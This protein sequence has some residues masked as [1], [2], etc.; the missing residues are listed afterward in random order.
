MHYYQHS[1]ADFNNAT[2]HL[3]R[4]ERSIYRDLIDMYYDTEKPLEADLNKLARR[5][6]VV[7]D[8]EK[9]A[10]K[11]VLDDFFTLKSDGW[12]QPRC[13]QELEE[14][15]A[16]GEEIK[17]REDNE[18]ERQR[19]HRDERKRLFSE[20]REKNVVPKWDIATEPLRALHSQHCNAPATAETLPETELKR[21]C[22]APA[23]AITNNHKP[24]TNNHKPITKDTPVSEIE[25]TDEEIPA[26][27]VVLRDLGVSIA[28][29]RKNLDKITALVH[30]GATL[31]HFTAGLEVASE[32]E[33]GFAYALGVVK[34]RL[35][36]EARPKARASPKSRNMT[37]EDYANVPDASLADAVR[38]QHE[39]NRPH[40][41]D[42]RT[43]EAPSP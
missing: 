39:L 9:Q 30:R 33:K 17:S 20:L 36:D 43:L 37:R 32:A 23:T 11:N 4:L 42:G 41:D 29:Q 22:N 35:D 2:R 25:S 13:D 15:L 28:E 38:K 5:A 19:R 6:L 12:H 3:T 27:C 14:Y 21:D 8:E 34:T 1:I 40:A 16:N 10:L 26:V 31:E 7:S 18:K 24:L